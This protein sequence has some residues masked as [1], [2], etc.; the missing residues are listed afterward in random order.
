MSQVRVLSGHML[1]A[2]WKAQRRGRLLRTFAL[3]NMVAIV[4]TVSTSGCGPD[5]TGSIPVGHPFA[6]VAQRP[7]QQ[8]FN[9]MCE[10]STPSGGTMKNSWA[11]TYQVA[12][13]AQVGAIGQPSYGALV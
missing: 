12:L 7:E 10:G 1:R 5:S 9:L 13:Q 2:G 4:I 6:P 8:T 11:D 3:A